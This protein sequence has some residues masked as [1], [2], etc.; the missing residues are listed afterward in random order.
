MSIAW[1][2]P[3]ALAGVALVV[4]PIAIH[5]LVR[6]HA[7]T[8]LYPS[9]RFLR[10]TQLAAFRRRTLQDAALLL[11][12]AAI[13][14][15]AAIALAGPVLQTPARTAAYANRISRAPVAIDQRPL[16]ADS[17]A[18]A[19]RWLNRQPPS[20]REIVI[21]GAFRRGD[22][23]DSELA[24][25]PPDIGVRFEPIAASSTAD[26]SAPVLIR[27]DG[28]LHRHD[29]PVHFGS[30]STQVADGV[31]TPVSNDLITIVARPADTPLAD[32]ALRASLDAG[33]PW[34][35]F[36]RRV[37]VVWNGADAS[38]VAPDARVIRMPVP[39]PASIAADAVRAAL[40]PDARPPGLV[41]PVMITADQ[42]ATWSRRPGPPSADAP[43]A[44]EGDRRWLW[45]MA[46]A[47]LAVEWW[48]RRP[49]SRVTRFGGQ[50]SPGL[51]TEAHE[52]VSKRE[53][54]LEARVA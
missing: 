34:S 20:A 41:E 30:D 35:D 52:D 29:R 38:E 49:P 54:R 13:L 4:L 27:R 47:L 33:I 51:P 21:S 17:L 43:L 16:L 12:R 5:L 32:A 50:P 42:L 39:S 14:A 7:R 3:A 11:C 45:A 2:L 23:G 24:A 36:S 40:A 9:L 18:D 31:M 10:E 6:Q 46:L 15:L 48:L 53:R 19:V 26:T 8:Q 28:A 25:V 44:D 37:V 22:I 1:L